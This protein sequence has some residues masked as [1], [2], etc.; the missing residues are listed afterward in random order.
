MPWTCT[1]NN[2]MIA[3]HTK[4]VYSILLE[5]RYFSIETTNGRN[6]TAYCKFEQEVGGTKYQFR[7]R[8]DRM[9]CSK[10]EAERNGDCE[11]DHFAWCFFQISKNP[12]LKLTKSRCSRFTSVAEALIQPVLY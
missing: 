12:E 1:A 8:V 11:I 5:N 3:G 4:L 2:S 7:M 6:S 9:D 10:E